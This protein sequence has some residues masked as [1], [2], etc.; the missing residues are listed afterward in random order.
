MR[1]VGSGMFGFASLGMAVVLASAAWGA[2]LRVAKAPPMAAPAFNWTGG[3]VGVDVGGGWYNDGNLGLGSNVTSVVAPGNIFNFP[4]PGGN[5]AGVTA[6]A[7]AGYN[8]QI[9]R[10]VIGAETDINYIDIKSQRAGSASTC[11]FGAPGGPL[12]TTEF[13]NAAASSKV[14]WFGTA[15]IRL[16]V[17]PTERLL[18]YATGGLA[19]GGV[20]TSRSD[21]ATFSTAVIANRFWQGDT[22]ETRLGW[23]VGGGAEAALTDHIILRAEYL[24]VDLGNSSV[25]ASSLGAAPPANLVYYTANRD[26]RFSV[27]RA[28]LSYKF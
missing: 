2:D 7:L 5:S 14:D 26:T 3:Y 13:F 20:Q 24:Y 10:T 18:V 25:V 11:C 9:G 23:S 15:R 28:A 16:G 21:S 8:Y 17:V 12:N 27:G 19:Y 4:I 22:S 1:I 6:G